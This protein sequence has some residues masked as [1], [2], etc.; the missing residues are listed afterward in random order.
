M[1][2]LPPGTSKWNKIEHRLFS[3]ITMNWK[4]QPLV[5]Y[6]V[7][8]DLIGATKTSTG[9]TVHCELDSNE[10]LKG[11]VVSDQKV[12][13]RIWWKLSWRH[14]LQRGEV[15]VSCSKVNALNGRL[16]S[17]RLPSVHLPHGDLAGG[18]QCPEQHGR[19]FR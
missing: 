17:Q 2:H 4:A 19:C 18:E 6:Q 9:L 5:S 16:L 12:V 13:S 14:H 15:I 11:V 1:N 10:Y 3:F 8:V 7:I